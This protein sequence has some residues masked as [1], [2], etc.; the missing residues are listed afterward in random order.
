VTF[1][2]INVFGIPIS[3]SPNCRSSAAVDIT[4]TSLAPVDPGSPP[5]FHFAT[6]GLLLSSYALPQLTGC[7]PFN[8]LI[9]QAVAGPGNTITFDLSAE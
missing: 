1:P 5:G 9:S 6:G 7:G 3:D 8:N 4:F 2:Q